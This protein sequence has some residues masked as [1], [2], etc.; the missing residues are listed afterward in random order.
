MSRAAA[1]VDA[2][3][4]TGWSLLGPC[5]EFDLS[6]V[7]DVVVVGQ[8]NVA[9]DCARILCKPPAE[10]A[11]TDI[12]THALQELRRSAVSRVSM[13]GRRGHVQAAFTIKELREATRL[14]GCVFAVDAGARCATAA[15]ERRRG[16]DKVALQRQDRERRPETELCWLLAAAVLQRSWSSGRQQLRRRRGSRGRRSESSS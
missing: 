5:Q 15:H 2:A 1:R 13:V 6:K 11:S 12:A 14:D 16:R 8:G 7:T 9:L 10:L 4:L 3:G